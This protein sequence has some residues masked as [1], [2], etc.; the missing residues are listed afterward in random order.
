MSS[1]EVDP[2]WEGWKGQKVSLLQNHES[3]LRTDIGET[4]GRELELTLERCHP[5]ISP[6]PGKPPSTSPRTDT[7]Y[8]PPEVL[9]IRSPVEEY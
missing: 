6:S 1:G 3:R 9:E 2:E 4:K 5:R 7:I 8:I